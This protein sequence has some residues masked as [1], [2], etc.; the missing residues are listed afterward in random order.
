MYSNI[1]PLGK[2]SKNQLFK[3]FRVLKAIKKEIKTTKNPQKLLSLSNQFY[4]NIPHINIKL[5]STLNDIDDKKKLLNYM[6]TQI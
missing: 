5:L 4:I 3:G 2:M 1:F 6:Y